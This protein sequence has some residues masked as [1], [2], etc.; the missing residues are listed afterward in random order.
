MEQRII[1]AG[2]GG[3]GIQALGKILIY[4]GMEQGLQ[5]SLLPSYGPEMRGGTTNCHVVISDEA[6]GSPLIS[7]ADYAMVFNL[8]SFH[9]FQG[10]VKSGGVL[11][12]N[13]SLVQEKSNRTDIQTLYL[14]CN[15]I[16]VEL[17]DV[18]AANS[19]MLGAFIAMTKIFDLENMHLSMQKLFGKNKE[20]IVSLNMQ[21]IQRGMEL[22]TT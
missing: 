17:G 4:T 13:S 3:Q 11:M 14:P 21:A 1:V 22:I 12:V 7:A 8:P 15:Q 9:K 6:V 2:F 18:R 5:V 19:V 10:M 16:A 20:K